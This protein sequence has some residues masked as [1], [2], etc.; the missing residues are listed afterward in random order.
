MKKTLIII[1]A[2][3]S[4]ITSNLMALQPDMK[5]SQISI[6][7]IIPISINS[8]PGVFLFSHKVGDLIEIKLLVLRSYMYSDL[9][10]REL[11]KLITRL[12]GKPIDLWPKTIQIRVMKNEDET[13]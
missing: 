11:V 5:E 8:I 13:L 1:L 2:G 10:A 7:N 4:F 6:N 12:T 9:K 3:F